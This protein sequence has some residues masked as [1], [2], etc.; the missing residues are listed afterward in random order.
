MKKRWLYGSLIIA[1]V[2]L[3]VCRF[4]RFDGLMVNVGAWAV[5]VAGSRRVDFNKY[6][7]SHSPG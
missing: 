7:I 1:L 3:L 4:V 2:W 6:I 5:A